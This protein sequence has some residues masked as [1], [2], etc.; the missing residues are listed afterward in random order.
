MK[1]TVLIDN[2]EAN[3]CQC[4][5]GLSFYIEYKEKKFLLDTGSSNKFISN[6]S[7]LDVRLIDVDYG[8]LSHAHYDHSD[9]IDSFFE[10]NKKANFYIQ[11]SSKENY[12]SKRL[13]I[14]KYIGIKKG[15]LNDYS[16]RIIYTNNVFDLYDG[17]KIIGHSSKDL[18]KIGI[19]EHMF[20]KTDNGYIPDDFSH[21]QSLVFEL[22]NGII[23]F[24]SCSHGGIENIFSEIREVY[25][26]QK[27]LAFFGGLHSFNKSD[28]E[29]NALANIIKNLD[30]DKIYTGHCTGDKAFKILKNVLNDKV[31]Q[32]KC[33]FTYDF[34]NK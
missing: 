34:S 18:Y 17:V 3:N 29:V 28:K 1:I 8:I 4:E 25:P 6:A 9:G 21:E 22:D 33:G 13:F 30:I 20:L 15:I 5:W 16:S 12:Y 19:K 31:D 11:K 10:V 23:V 14:K 24:N 2:I 27:I 26:N 32:F 7:L